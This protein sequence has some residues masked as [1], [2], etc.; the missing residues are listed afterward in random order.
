MV[1]LV[2]RTLA[3]TVALVAA[4]TAF[5]AWRWPATW[6]LPV[7]P[8]GTT[9]QPADPARVPSSDDLAPASPV[10]GWMLLVGVIALLIG[11]W[12]LL[13]LL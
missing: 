12:L 8:F 10:L 2:L 7:R 6:R 5:F 11:A 4:S 9:N 13:A 1:S 3:V